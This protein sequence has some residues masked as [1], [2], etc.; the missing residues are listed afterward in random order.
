MTKGKLTELIEKM[1]YN[2]DLPRNYIGAS[3][4]GSD[5]LRQI[6]Y[7]FKGEKTEGV[8]NKIRRTWEIGRILEGFVVDLIRASGIKVI[9]NSSEFFAPDDKTNSLTMDWTSLSDPDLPYFKGH[10]DGMLL[11][12]QAILEIKT[13]KDAS[14]KIFVKDGCAKWNPKYYAQVQSYMGMSGLHTAY[15]IV[16]N[17]D[18]SE[19]WDEQITFQSDYYELIKDKVKMIYE[20]KIP[21][22]KI[23]GSPL[24][25]QCKMCKYRKVCHG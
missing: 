16:L 4:I 23:N 3:S 21:P 1:D 25:F 6:W 19:L 10:Y 13:A 14:F 20:A 24:W 2:D 8:S 15:I 12:Y 5:C 22:P 18:N 11:D 9:N 7:E 17:K